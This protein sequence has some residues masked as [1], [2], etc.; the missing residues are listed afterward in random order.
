MKPTWTYHPSS[1]VSPIIEPTDEGFKT[2]PRWQIMAYA[3][4]DEYHSEDLRLIVEVQFDGYQ[5]VT[6]YRT[7][8]KGERILVGYADDSL[9]HRHVIRRLNNVRPQPSKPKE[10]EAAIKQAVTNGKHP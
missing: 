6:V 8:R 3:P 5:Q 10:W 1:L 7:G 9:D 4:P 2:L